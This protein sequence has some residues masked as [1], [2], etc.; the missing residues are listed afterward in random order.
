MSE[1]LS[2]LSEGGGGGGGGG[3][4]G[5]GVIGVFIAMELWSTKLSFPLVVD[6][7]STYSHLMST[8]TVDGPLQLFVHSSK[9]SISSKAI[10]G[11]VGG[12]LLHVSVRESGYFEG[13]V[14]LERSPSSLPLV[15]V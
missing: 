14:S 5:G 8:S 12:A 2:L 13:R 15:D 4:E 10:F 1:S 7:L 3:D 11:E 9:C 6:S